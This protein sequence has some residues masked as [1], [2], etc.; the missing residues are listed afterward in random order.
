MGNVLK[1]NNE[2]AS[3][4]YAKRYPPSYPEARKGCKP[5]RLG[6]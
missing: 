5:M 3:K 2:N 1:E 6:G 4:S